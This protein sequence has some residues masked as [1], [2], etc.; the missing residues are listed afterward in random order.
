M[1]R[2]F[3]L[4]ILC[5][6]LTAQAQW[7][8]GTSQKTGLVLCLHLT[9]STADLYSPMQTADPIPISKWSLVDGRLTLECKSIGLMM[10]LTQ[11]GSTLSGHWKQ[12][13]FKEDITFLP[14]DTLFSLQ[15]PQ[16]PQPPYP[17]DEE[18]VTADYTDSQGNRVHLEG[19]LTYPRNPGAGG[20]SRQYPCL[21]LVSGSGQQ[22]RDEEIMQHKPFLVLADYLTRRGIAVLRY[23]D[24]NM[25]A[26][27]GPLDSADTR[28]F[29]EDA[30]A[31][32]RALKGNPH[33]DPARLGI[34]GHSE[35]GAI[36]PMVAARN[37]EVKFV[38]MLAG[39]GCTGRDVLLQQNEAIY[40]AN[41]LS[42]RLLAVRMAC[43]HDLFALPAGSSQKNHKAVI[44]RYTK[45][46]SKAEIDSIGL[47]R[48]TAAAFKEQMESRWMQA[49][50]ALDPADY[51]SKV[52]CPVLAL[53]GSKDCQ[54]LAHPNLDRIKTLCPQADCRELP[55]LNHLFQ[56]CTTG[57]PDEYT[58]IEETF[59]PEA[60]QLI[61]DF[62]HGTK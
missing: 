32:F 40:R 28:L 18:T 55:D 9:D 42:E 30:E 17:Y 48:G 54:V 23:D 37:K 25:G 44:S 5:L 2:I 8:S 7:Y 21:V 62:I 16:T 58:L 1:K 51:L 19:T 41:G 14:T 12:G 15:R 22:N 31:M 60:M 61:A 35:G 10:E 4:T 26:S 38:V 50:L 13:L 46:L 27:T 52:K 45:D 24:R 59:A 11:R 56:H 49:F 33:V 34:G 3:L 29:A 6:G 39:Q 20:V 36:A 43:M 47:G 53:N 57:S